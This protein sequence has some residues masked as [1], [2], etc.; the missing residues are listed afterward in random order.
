MAVIN[1][2]KNYII[3]FMR[4]YFSFQI[5]QNAEMHILWCLL[6]SNNVLSTKLQLF[7]IIGKVHNK[8]YMTKTYDKEK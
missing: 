6:R 2:F 8:Q 1:W 5:T 3:D 4:F 7:N